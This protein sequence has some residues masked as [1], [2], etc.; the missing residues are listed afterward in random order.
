MSDAYAVIIAP[1]AVLEVAKAAAWW[2]KNRPAAPRLFQAELDR[3]LLRLAD[4]IE[5]GP[6]VRVR[7]RRGLYVL[8]LQRTGYSCSTSSTPP[9]SK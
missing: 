6:R 8:V 3:A 4:G 5:V 9:K 2:N 7:G 1:E